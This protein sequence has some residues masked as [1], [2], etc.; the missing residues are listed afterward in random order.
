LNCLKIKRILIIRVGGEQKEQEESEAE[1]GHCMHAQRGQRK[2]Q[3]KR[4][5]AITPTVLYTPL[6]L[7]DG[8]DRFDFYILQ[9]TVYYHVV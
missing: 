3:G 8:E 6:S 4:A 9:S 5:S 7:L 2:R 1:A